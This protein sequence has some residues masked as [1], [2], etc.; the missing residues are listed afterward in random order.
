[1]TERL[2]CGITALSC[3]FLTFVAR[4]A[5]D[6]P[7]VT[8][9][10]NVFRL[11]LAAA[12]AGK[13]FNTRCGTG[14]INC[15]N[16]LT[17]GVTDSTEVFGFCFTAA[18]AGIGLDTGCC[19]GGLGC[20]LAAVPAVV[21]LVAKLVKAGRANRGSG[22][23]SRTAVLTCL[24]VCASAAFGIRMA[25]LTGS[26]VA[27]VFVNPLSKVVSFCCCAVK[28]FCRIGSTAS[29]AGIIICSNGCAGGVGSYVIVL[30]LLSIEGVVK[31]FSVFFTAAAAYRQSSAGC[32]SARVACRSLTGG[33]AE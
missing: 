18:A 31:I 29:R 7:K 8:D 6:I 21:K 1:M 32:V 16:T 23:G 27:S 22:T 19:T 9:R 3:T 15:Y 24:I 33:R 17:E 5:F 25:A 11:F 14:G 26:C 20:Y 28:G 4:T 2:G 12:A 13:G 30:C 10:R